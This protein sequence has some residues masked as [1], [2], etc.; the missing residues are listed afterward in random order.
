MSNYTRDNLHHFLTITYSN[1]KRLISGVPVPTNHIP[2]WKSFD[3][4]KKH[5]KEL[6]R[7]DLANNRY[8]IHRKVRKGSFKYQ[9]RLVYHDLNYTND[10]FGDV[11][12]KEIDVVSFRNEI[13]AGITILYGNEMNIEGYRRVKDHDHE[14]MQSILDRK[15]CNWK[16][17]SEYLLKALARIYCSAKIHNR[18]IIRICSYEHRVEFRM[19]SGDDELMWFFLSSK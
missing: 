2:S 10:I 8:V 14:N 6:L 11:V 17:F 4:S 16:G 1:H 18:G 19:R 5:S 9:D 12:N 3:G 7:I 15:I 13:I